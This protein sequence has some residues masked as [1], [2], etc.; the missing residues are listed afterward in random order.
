MKLKHIEQRLERER[1]LPFIDRAPQVGLELQLVAE[2]LVQARVEQRELALAVGLARL[3]LR[4][5]VRPGVRKRAPGGVPA[6]SA[7]PLQHV[8][9]ANATK[10]RFARCL[11]RDHGRWRS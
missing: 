3:Q 5:A 7:A 11:T 9:H 1:E 8:H 4:V 6:A 10:R 2:L